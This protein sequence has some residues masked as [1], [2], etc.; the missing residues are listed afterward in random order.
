[1]PSRTYIS[2]DTPKL[3]HRKVGQVAGGIVDRSVMNPFSHQRWKSSEGWLSAERTVAVLQAHNQYQKVRG[4]LHAAA[5]DQLYRN[6]SGGKKAMLGISMLEW[7]SSFKMIANAG[8]RIFRSLRALRHGDMYNAIR[9]LNTN[10]VAR[11]KAMRKRFD[12]GARLD[13]LW[14]ELNFGWAPLIVDIGQAIQVLGQEVPTERV[15]ARSSSALEY[16]NSG[17][18][19]GDSW[20]NEMNGQVRIQYTTHVTGVNPNVL[21]AKQLGFTN[22]AQIAW[23]VV[24]FSFVVDWFLPVNKFLGGFDASLGV[25][26]G[27]VAMSTMIRSEGFESFKSPSMP[28]R[29]YA[30]VSSCMDFSRSI[31]GALPM[32]SFRDRLVLPTSSLWQATTSV[33]L[34]IQQLM[35]VRSNTRV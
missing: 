34:V 11:A 8:G 31:A 32:P 15:R 26:L 22:P 30:V 18:A 21:L 3:F 33:A 1:M 10:N 5:Y 9:H 4:R 7:N 16:I 12:S 28:S 25:S 13:R 23:D 19:Y 35:A 14:L 20:T 27:S 24:P 6:A 29:D 2:V 17:K